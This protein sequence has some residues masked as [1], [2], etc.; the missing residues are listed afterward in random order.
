[1]KTC[2]ECD[3]AADCAHH[4][5]PRVLGG[6]RTV[7]LCGLCHAKIHGNVSDPISSTSTSTPTK[8]ALAAKAAKGERVGELPYG[9]RLAADGA[10]LERDEAEQSVLALV[11][12]LR[13]GGLSQRA[14]VAE[15][16]AQ[17]LVS[18]AGR[19]FGQTQV[20]RL[21]HAAISAGPNFPKSPSPSFV[22][23]NA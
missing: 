11:R 23:P 12:E 13:A 19:P 9:F 18:R 8:A 1:M 20:C 14:I 10:H 4:V 16:A 21:I 7:P 6:K 5:V 3:A 15:L 2:F 22:S 17:G